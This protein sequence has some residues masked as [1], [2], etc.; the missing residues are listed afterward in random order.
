MGQLF[1]CGSGGVAAGHELVEELLVEQVE[2]RR[3]DTQALQP[4]HLVLDHRV[5]FLQQRVKRKEN[6]HCC[7]ALSLVITST[8]VKCLSTS[9]KIYCIWH[10]RRFPFLLAR[11]IDAKP[12]CG[13]DIS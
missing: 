4:R 2:Q 9:P 12:C 13:Q 11:K 7:P 5:N 8:E 1:L 3:L 6:H 10:R